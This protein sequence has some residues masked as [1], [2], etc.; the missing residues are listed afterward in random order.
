MAKR[1]T[2][3]DRSHLIRIEAPAGT[4]ALA[5]TEIEA[6]VPAAILPWPIDSQ[7]RERLAAGGVQNQT[8]YTVN[9]GYRTDVQPTYIAHELCCTQ[10]VF[11]ILA[12]IPT[13][14]RDALDLTCVVAG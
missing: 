11:Q 9:I 10:R 6:K 3:G 4:L 13:D 12:L 1:T 7:P 5:E 8:N 2:A 14:R